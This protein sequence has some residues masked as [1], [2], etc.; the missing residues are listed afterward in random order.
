MTLE[1]F[2]DALDRYGADLAG[3]PEALRAEAERLVASS[4]EAERLYRQAERLD[5]LFSPGFV[6]PP[7]S[8]ARIVAH[9]TQPIRLRLMARIERALGFDLFG[10]G[11]AH[12]GGLAACLLIGLAI[13][14]A[15]PT[16]H[17]LSPGLLD[18][19]MGAHLDQA[20]D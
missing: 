10:F 4:P 9:A 15:T 11:W 1:E 5:R 6:P 16:H 14:T 19:A 13:G 7:P 3:W 17:P 8:V 20:D 18:L 12:A 2:E